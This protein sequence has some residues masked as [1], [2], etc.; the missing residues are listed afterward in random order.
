M[1]RNSALSH[2]DSPLAA[3]KNWFSRNKTPYV[4]IGGVASSYL[5]MPRFTAD[6]DAVID[7]SGL[8]LKKLLE[9]AS[10]FNLKPRIRNCLSFARQNRI[11]LLIHTPSSINA[12]VSLGI[13]PFE[14]MAIKHA[15][16][17]KIG[18]TFINFPRVEDLIIFKAVAGRPQDI[19]DIRALLKIESRLNTKYIIKTVS[20]F[21]RVLEKPEI[22]TDLKRL[23]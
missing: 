16:K 1:K 2:L 4:I 8:D 7:S 17:K 23:L 20:E 5:G 22:V 14:L 3:I 11:L 6:V 10:A 18:Q 15:R 9:S 21:A 13:L 19:S 12:D